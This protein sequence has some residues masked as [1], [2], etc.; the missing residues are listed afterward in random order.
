MGLGNI[1]GLYGLLALIPFILIY[2]F[3]PKPIDK[4][5]PSLMFFMRD[6]KHKKKF[7]FLRRLL[8][9]LLFLIQLLAILALAFSL[10]EPF[11][12]ISKDAASGNTVLVID[13]SASMQTKYEGTTRFEY[14]LKEA[15]S[16]M[17]GKVSIVL[18][19]LTPEIA[20]ENSLQTEASRILN[21]VKPKD[22]STNVKGSMDLADS[23]LEKTKGNVI[24]FSDFITTMDND[25]VIVS[26][27]LLNARGN[28]VDFFNLANEAENVGF[29][30]LNIQKDFTEATIKNFNKEEKTMAIVLVKNNEAVTQKEVK[31]GARSKEKITLETLPGLSTLEIKSDD[32][33]V[34]DN[35]I[36]ISSPLKDDIKVLLI[37]NDVPRSIKNA[38]EAAK[39]I[40]VDIAEPPIVPDINHDI[41]IV[42]NV[43]NEELLPG[44][45]G[46]VKRYVEKGGNLIIASQERIAQIDMLDL[47][48]IN[49]LGMGNKS[50][51][52]VA[53]QNEVTKDMDFGLVNRFIVA[54]PSQG[55]VSFLNSEEGSTLMAYKNYGNGK[56]IY[57]GLF[58][59]ENDFRFSPDYPIFWNNMVNFMLDTEDINDYNF[60]IGDKSLI[61]K[62]GFYEEGIK[63]V[64]YNFLDEAESDVSMD[65][66][67]FSKEQS[68]FIEKDVQEEIEFD[69]TMPVLILASLVLL[70]EI[71]YIKLRGDL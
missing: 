60:K 54:E 38:L 44:T 17:N 33:L 23:L 7:L 19:S 39:Y 9:N 56:I 53:S 14:A 3:K 48:P 4:T 25:D 46:D 31:M 1:I 65:S 41:V 51:V 32:D 58:D 70:F 57:Y 16:R 22:M 2:L 36:Y 11:I 69:F 24:V 63:T 28:S 34:V 42:S 66:D 8:T 15:K 45:F 37:S 67:L 27:R 10:A 68:D 35:K 12:M 50:N 18:A 71:F 29:V 6:Q 62:A 47:L 13:A 49:I 40:T 52:V 30:D 5:M 59:D 20:L 43:K 26:R 64:A 21:T 55:A 61:D